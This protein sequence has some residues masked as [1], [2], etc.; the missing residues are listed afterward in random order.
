MPKISICIPAYNQTYFLRK[1]LNSI[2]TQ[3]FTD[4]EVIITDDSTTTDVEELVA[5]FDFKGKLRYYHNSPSLGSPRNWNECTSKA[6][7]EY[8][9]IMHHDDWFSSDVS[10]QSLVTLLESSPENEFVFCGCNNIAIDGQNL[11]YHYINEDQVAILNST[12]E[13]LFKSNVIGSP[14]VTLFKKPENLNFDDK[15][16]Y[17]VDIEFYIRELKSGKKFVYTTDA[18]VN[19]GHSPTQV[20]NSIINNKRELIFEYSYTFQKLDHT[21]NA[22]IFYFD[23][24]WR[25][26]TDLNILSVSELVEFDWEGKI[27][28][29]VRHCIY[30]NKLLKYFGSRLSTPIRWATYFYSSRYAR[31]K[32][33]KIPQNEV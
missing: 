22:F 2:I 11:F 32:Y 10:L 29:F 14:S 24:F 23:T 8:I 17:L 21:K 33:L 25:L 18:L 30:G 27:P 3:H 7:G 12:P 15:I 26:I 6:L 5:E 20:T 19:I 31:Y 9:K 16:K 1:N 4:Y 13:L 28:L